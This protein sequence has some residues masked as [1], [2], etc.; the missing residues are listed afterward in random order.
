VNTVNTLKVSDQLQARAAFSTVLIEYESEWA[1]EPSGWGGED[2][3]SLSYPCR[4]SKPG[5]PAP[6]LVVVLT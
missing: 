4:Q 3:K 2:R 6:S 5:R 1:P